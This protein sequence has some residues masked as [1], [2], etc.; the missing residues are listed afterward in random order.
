[1]EDRARLMETLLQDSGDSAAK[2]CF[3]S[4]HIQAK[5]RFYFYTLRQAFENGRWPEET[6]WEAKLHEA[7]Q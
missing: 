3:S 6:V 1:M 4:P 5:L 7:V 2:K